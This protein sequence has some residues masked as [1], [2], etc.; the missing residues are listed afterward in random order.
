[1]TELNIGARDAKHYDYDSETAATHA[2][3]VVVSQESTHRQICEAKEWLEQRGNAGDNVDTDA[4]ERLH[5]A[6]LGN[7]GEAAVRHAFELLSGRMHPTARDIVGSPA[8][9]VVYSQC[10][11][12]VYRYEVDR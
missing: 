5:T 1:M 2:D 4:L 11:E 9:Y 3:S 10:G 7:D 12:R 6:V 8:R